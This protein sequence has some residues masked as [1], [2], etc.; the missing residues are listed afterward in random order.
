MSRFLAHIEWATAMAQTGDD[1]LAQE[2]QA[3]RASALGAAGRRLE[4]ALAALDAAADDSRATHLD[5]AGRIAWE[6]MVM[7]EMAGLRDWDAV[8]RLYAIPAS[9]LRRMGASATLKRPGAG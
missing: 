1:I 7:R 4:R 6:F 5:Q 2:L 3:E 9:V 8:V